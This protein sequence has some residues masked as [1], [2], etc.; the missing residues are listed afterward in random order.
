MP[1]PLRAASR[2]QGLQTGAAQRR[3]KSAERTGP[4]AASAS[5]EL[6]VRG[7]KSQDVSGHQDASV[8]FGFAN[9]SLRRRGVERN[10]FFGKYVFAGAECCRGC[11]GVLIGGKADIDG[12]DRG[13]RQS[14][15]EEVYS[16]E[17]RRNRTSRH[18]CPDCHRRRRDRQLV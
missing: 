7:K 6:F 17:F 10:G 3:R 12:I 11:G 4:P 13:I 2:C 1:P 16:R 9:E 15:S 14:F 5:S 18:H 8:G